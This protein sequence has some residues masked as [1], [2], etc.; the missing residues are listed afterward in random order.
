MLRGARGRRGEGA[1]RGRGGVPA[2]GAAGGAAGGSAGGAAGGGGGGGSGVSPEFAAAAAALGRAPRADGASPASSSDG[3]SAPSLPLPA[4]LRA[5]APKGRCVLALLSHFGDLTPWEYAQELKERALPALEAAQVPLVFCGLGS[6]EAAALFAAQTGVDPANVFALD[7]G[8][9]YE[10]LGFS[11][12]FAPDAPVSPY[13]KLLPMLLGVGSPGT[14]QEVV[15]GYVGD[16]DAPEVFAGGSVFDVLGSGYQRPFELASRRLLNMASI[17]P[18]WRDLAP[19]DAG[20]LT[21]QGGTFVFADGET[22]FAHRASG[23]LDRAPVDA[24]LEAA[25]SAER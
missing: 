8:A 1:G 9:L 11:R 25:L 2:R 17:L 20:L 15:R 6:A 12:G 19:A 22:R 21:A 4:A 13:L 16:R 3:A 7:S 24:V 18:R 23:I 10:E 14:V 5:G